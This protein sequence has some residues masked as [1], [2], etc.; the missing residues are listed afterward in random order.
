MEKSHSISGGS[1]AQKI[2]DLHERLHL[3]NPK[4]VRWTA[5]R[6]AGV[7]SAVTRGSITFPEALVR[8]ELSAEELAR[9]MLN[10]KTIGMVG[11]KS[12]K[13]IRL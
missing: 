11:L 6:K 12:T 10:Y 9:W 8:Y 2:L 7:V 3:P 5:S 1:F 13:R 4:C